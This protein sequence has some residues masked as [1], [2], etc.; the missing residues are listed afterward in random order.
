MK[1]ILTIFAGR[2]M[3]LEILIQY[4]QKAIDNH[5]LDEIHFWNY[6]RN[7]DDEIYIKSISN[8]KRTS[9]SGGGIYNQIFTPIINN[10]FSF[11]TVAKNDVHVK[12][13]DVYEIVL[14]GFD[15]RISL[16]RKN[17]IEV[18]RLEQSDVVTI[19]N[20]TEFTIEIIDKTLTI[21][22]NNISF[23][24][25]EM[26]EL[27]EIKD[28][29]FKT[30]H[31]SIGDFSYEMVRNPQFFFMDTCNKNIWRDYYQHYIHDKYSDDVIIKCDD[32][33]VFIDLVKLPKF[34]D[35]VKNN[36]Y[37]VVFANTINNGVAAYYQQN[38]Y[39]LIPFDLMELEYPKGGL[40]G[41]LWADGKK[42]ERLHRFFLENYKTFLDYPYPEEIIK[43]D[44]RFSINFFGCKGCK[45]WEISNGWMDDEH[46]ITVFFVK[47][48]N[49]KNVLYTDLYVSH[50]SF[51]K[52]VET[53]ID[54]NSLRELYTSFVQT[55]NQI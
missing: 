6:A 12:L 30:G 47:N 2:K 26:D 54:L 48:Y 43:I 20:S 3:N 37:N 16:I 32:D 44:T 31:G 42:A 52:Q 27:F 28:I 38:K 23:M 19:E 13:S 39:G 5:I 50:L 24:T 4:L 36:E 51:Y 34:I 9:S 35:F 14:G 55:N 17:D 33:I 25:Y 15:N 10:R 21:L 7:P 41:S 22:K 40:E 45:W 18:H 11:K 8:L 46:N 29:F 1:K 53:G 49:Y